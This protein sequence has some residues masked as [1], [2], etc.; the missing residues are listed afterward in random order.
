MRTQNVYL[1]VIFLLLVFLTNM[2]RAEEDVNS[3]FYTPPDGEWVDPIEGPK[4][5][6]YWANEVAKEKAEKSEK[7]KKE[8]EEDTKEQEQ[9]IVP[10]EIVAQDVL[11]KII[12]PKRKAKTKSLTFSFAAITHHGFSIDKEASP[13][14]KRKLTSSG[15]I[16]WNPELGVMYQNKNTVMAMSVIDDCYGNMA[17]YIGAGKKWNLTKHFSAGF[18]M[19]FY[20]RH[21]VPYE[22]MPDWMIHG[23]TNIIPFPFIIAQQD[24]PITKD[25]SASIILNTNYAINQ[26]TF[27]LKKEF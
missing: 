21:H 13:L 10:Q 9:K 26:L 24:I 20:I 4:I 3:I 2:A 18:M 22:K 19:G 7:E 23:N 25:W 15:R 6:E 1:I 27:G 17:G 14:L 12:Q 5:Y 16:V 8:K 11:Q